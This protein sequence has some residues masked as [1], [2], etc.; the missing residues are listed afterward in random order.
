[1]MDFHCTAANVLGVSQRYTPPAFRRPSP[2][3][4]YVWT[5]PPRKPIR[6]RNS[7]LT[8]RENDCFE[9]I[10]QH[11]Q[12]HG[13]APLYAEMATALGLGRERARQLS[14]RLRRKGWIM[15]APGWQRTIR[16][17]TTPMRTDTPQGPPALTFR[18]ATPDEM[19]LD[20]PEG[21]TPED[22]YRATNL[23]A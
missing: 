9:A 8:Q 13:R 22:I 4:P 3:A 10:L 7:E 1:M 11:M 21:V 14:L 23:A 20:M 16:I 15:F 19:A 5:P 18:Q 2:P 6:Y 12:D 17:R